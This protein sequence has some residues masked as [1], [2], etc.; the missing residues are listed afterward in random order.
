MKIFEII[1]S[2]NG[3]S[4]YLSALVRLFVKDSCHTWVACESF[5][6]YVEKILGYFEFLEQKVYLYLANLA[7]HFSIFSLP[8]KITHIF[9][10][11]V[12]IF[13]R[14]TEACSTA[15]YLVGANYCL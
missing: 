2:Y 1:Y 10:F 8:Y 9:Y 3:P 7:R 6:E 14:K 12:K 11:I 15:S 13:R 4:K 5:G